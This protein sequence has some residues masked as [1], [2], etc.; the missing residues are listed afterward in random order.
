M[1]Y[2]RPGGNDGSNIDILTQNYH[3]IWRDR[4]SSKLNPDLE[5]KIQ[6]ENFDAILGNSIGR[7]INNW[8]CSLCGFINDENDD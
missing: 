6:E 4:I 8:A 3:T 2:E 5:E 7:V 1:N